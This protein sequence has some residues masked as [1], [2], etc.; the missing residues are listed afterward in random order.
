VLVPPRF[1]IMAFA[2][3]TGQFQM[4][5]LWDETQSKQI[6]VREGD[7]LP[8]GNRV[9]KVDSLNWTVGMTTGSSR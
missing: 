4:A 3:A 1:R 9:T 8:D 7:V 2:P 6:V 5:H